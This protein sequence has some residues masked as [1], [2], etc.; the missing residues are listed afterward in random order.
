MS[1]NADYMCAIIK[2]IDNTLDGQFKDALFQSSRASKT[3]QSTMVH[4]LYIQKFYN[5]PFTNAG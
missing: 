3:A 2:L 4:D 1:H 5:I